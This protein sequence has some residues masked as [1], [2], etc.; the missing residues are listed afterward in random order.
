MKITKSYLKQIIKEELEHMEEA[1]KPYTNPDGK[2]ISQ[3]LSPADKAMTELMALARQLRVFNIAN[4]NPE[5]AQ[6]YKQQI[7]QLKGAD[8]EKIQAA[9]AT[10]KEFLQKPE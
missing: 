7:S 2:D 1:D 5:A 8:L 4:P 3:Y 10:M 9:I 6:A